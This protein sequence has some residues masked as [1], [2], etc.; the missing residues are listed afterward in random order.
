MA[1]GL[2]SRAGHGRAMRQR[3]QLLARPI[4]LP[5]AGRNS[6]A[7][8]G[9]GVAAYQPQPGS[10]DRCQSKAG[11]PLRG[12]RCLCTADHRREPRL[13]CLDR[14][15]N[16]VGLD[17]ETSSAAVQRRSLPNC[18]SY[19]KAARCARRGPTPALGLRPWGGP[20][21][22][23]SALRVSTILISQALSLRNRC[24][25]KAS[26]SSHNCHLSRNPGQSRKA[27]VGYGASWRMFSVS[28]VRTSH[29]SSVSSLW[30]CGPRSSLRL[31]MIS[32]RL[33][34]IRYMR[35]TAV[36][37]RRPVSSV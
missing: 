25:P 7:P 26:S 32:S 19:V 9:P 20:G 28:S 11:A 31:S 30:S 18:R 1:E 15:G 3:A 16:R 35:I 10:R 22:R 5:M 14:R 23:A 24:C 13:P 34:R 27:Q 21:R 6:R 2:Q 12:T 4:D 36:L 8:R 17:Q 33:Q 37:T 29:V